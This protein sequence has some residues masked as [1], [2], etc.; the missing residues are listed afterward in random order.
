[1]SGKA[2]K[3]LS[4]NCLFSCSPPRNKNERVPLGTTAFFESMA[5][6]MTA[7]NDGTQLSPTLLCVLIDCSSS[8]VWFTPPG[9][10]Q[11]SAPRSRGAKSCFSEASNVGVVI[12]GK[13]R[14]SLA[15]V[16]LL[17]QQR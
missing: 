11:T 14:K 4:T 5:S 6:S 8:S 15:S 10:I 2:A 16:L 17:N 1:M 9:G 7:H 12:A 3:V 13:R